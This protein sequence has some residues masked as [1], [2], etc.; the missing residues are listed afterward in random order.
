MKLIHICEE[1]PNPVPPAE[2]AG[3]TKF[4]YSDTAYVKEHVYP[5]LVQKID[6]LNKKA[7]KLNLPPI[8]LDVVGE[9][10]V[11]KGPDTTQKEKVYEV[12]IS[13]SAPKVAGY[14]FLATIDHKEGGNVIRTVPGY[15]ENEA[16]KDFYEARP[17]YCDHCK[18]ARHRIETYII[19]DEKAGT[20]RQIGRNCLADFLPGIDPKAI[21]HYF[22]M[23]DL[24]AKALKD[25][26]HEG[27]QRGRSRMYVHV[28]EILQI[29]AALV[30]RFGYR[31]STDAD[32]NRDPGSTANQVRTVLMPPPRDTRTNQEEQWIETG[33]NI[34]DADKAAATQAAAWFNGLSD[35]MKNSNDFYHNVDVLLKTGNVESKDIGYVVALFPA[36]ARANQQAQPRQGGG[37]PAAPQKSN[38]HLGAVGQKL[39]PTRVKITGT[40][41]LPNNF[42]YRAP[43][44]QLIR[45]EDAAGNAITWFNSGGEIA[46]Q[47]GQECT[48]TGTIK[49][50]DEFKGRKQ[51]TLTR[52]KISE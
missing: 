48:I 9:K 45:M 4:S 13:G 41:M 11:S 31:K 28:D 24:I 36:Y 1:T 49:K 16:I 18:K 2:E 40:Q 8:R 37:G 39:P 38:E 30:R 22:S 33:T 27:G 32:G 25:A 35:Q 7:M 34:T 42:G 10:M 5:Y 14:K 12:K 47:T 44:T 52:A 50:H 3:D 26:E 15:D 21:L 6:K 17:D 51:T 43:P 19:Q 20:L 23:R 29:G 46:L